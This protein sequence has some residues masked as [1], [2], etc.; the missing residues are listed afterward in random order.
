MQCFFVIL[1]DFI[2]KFF[3]FF[4]IILFSSFLA[5]GL[6]GS[7]MKK[8]VIII[9][10]I[11]VYYLLINTH[12]VQETF[13]GWYSSQSGCPFALCSYHGF[14]PRYLMGDPVFTIIYSLYF[15]CYMLK[16]IDD[17]YVG[18]YKNQR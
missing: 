5:G 6:F 14:R 8:S 9:I 4:L 12:G 13:F 17:D 3:A 16:S 18:P 15:I 2:S 10:L 1:I 11:L 7:L